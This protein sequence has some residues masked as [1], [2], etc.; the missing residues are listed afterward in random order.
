MTRRQKTILV[1]GSRDPESASLRYVRALFTARGHDVLLAD[2][3]QP[4]LVADLY[5]AGRFQ[6]VLGLGDESTEIV[7]RAMRT[8]PIGVPR[9]MVTTL[10]AGDTRAYVDIHDLIMMNP[11]VDVES[12]NAVSRRILVNAVGALCGMVEQKP[13]IPADRPLVAATMFGVTTPCVTAVRQQLERADFEVLVFHATGSGGRAMEALIEADY[14]AGVVDITTTEWADEVAGGLRSAGPDR[15]G[16]AGRRGIPQVVSVGALDM[17]NFGTID[18]VPHALRRRLLHRH[19]ANVTLM[20]TSPQEC[21][22]IGRR[23]ADKLNQARG[24]TVLV[25]PL[26]G[27]SMMDADGQPFHD[28]SADQALF[29]AL[30]AR[31]DPAIPV[32]EID[33]H[34]NDPVFA[35]AVVTQF[36]AIMDN[37]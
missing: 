20:R 35:D 7:T 29:D 25:L 11:V 37:R 6:G 16:A 28:V 4:A 30:R 9:L 24:P 26:R 1:L 33:A 19:H 22:E 14:F 15:L 3:E 21:A 36:L 31:V 13:D 34:I 5:A 10:A 32:I 12:L 23:I 17:V 18:T 8:L 27:I 2:A